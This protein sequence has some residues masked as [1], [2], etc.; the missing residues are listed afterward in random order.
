[1]AVVTEFLVR[2]LRELRAAQLID[3]PSLAMAI[4]HAPG[5]SGAPSAGQRSSATTIASCASS[6]AR[7]TS[8]TAREP[9]DELGQ[10]DAKD[11]GDR[12]R[13]VA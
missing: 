4:S 2:A 9:R 10:L 3:R 11:R 7:P 12:V 8:R 6:S 1:M 13:G 5:L